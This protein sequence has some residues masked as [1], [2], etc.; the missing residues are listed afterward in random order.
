IGNQP[1]AVAVGDFN[2]DG[3]ADLAASNRASNNVS[4]LLGNGDGTFA[5]AVNLGSGDEPYGIAVADFNLDGR[6]D[7]ATAHRYQG[8][9]V[10]LNINAPPLLTYP[11]LQ[12]LPVGGSLTI[13]PT[14]GPS[15]NGALTSVSVRPVTPAGF[16]G[17][18]F[19]SSLGV[20]T[21]N[22]AGPPGTYTV[23]VRATDNC[24]VM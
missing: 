13:P 7:L 6:P 4:V 14:S 21:V 9:F 23:T 15:N 5:A 18:V 1:L 24:G 22:N 8:L 10:L 19:S 17:N 11:D 12:I 20:I 3:K 16:T 2:L